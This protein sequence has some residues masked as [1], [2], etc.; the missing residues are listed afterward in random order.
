MGRHHIWAGW[1]KHDAADLHS[2]GARFESL[3]RHGYPDWGF[4]WFPFV[5]RLEQ[6]RFL[7]NHFPIIVRQLSYRWMLYSIDTDCVVKWT[8][9]KKQLVS[10]KFLRKESSGVM[11]PCSWITSPIYEPG[12]LPRRNWS[13]SIWKWRGGRSCWQLVT[14]SS[15][16]SSSLSR[17][18]RLF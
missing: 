14:R 1:Y 13:I 4:P 15:H 17:N 12:K 8:T 9:M 18:H 5:P 16:S 2:R 10:H 6:N 7:H 3:R 11:W